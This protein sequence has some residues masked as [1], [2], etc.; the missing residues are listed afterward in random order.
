MVVRGLRRGKM[1][2]DSDEGELDALGV[3]LAY[4]Y[5]SLSF[6]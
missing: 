5:I 4:R 1:S 2:C 6:V 3:T